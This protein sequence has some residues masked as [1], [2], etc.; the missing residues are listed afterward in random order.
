LNSFCHLEGRDKFVNQVQVTLSTEFRYPAET[1]IHA[2]RVASLEA[3][4]DLGP[5]FVKM[6]CS[7]GQIVPMYKA[8]WKPLFVEFLFPAGLSLP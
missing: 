5:S 4:A 2:S 7:L 6:A 1:Q 3:F 8:I